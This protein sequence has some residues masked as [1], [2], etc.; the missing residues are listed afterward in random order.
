MRE[1]E[2]AA[3][4]AQKLTKWAGRGEYNTWTDVEVGWFHAWYVGLLLGRRKAMITHE[5]TSGRQSNGERRER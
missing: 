5:Q 1:E 3:A 2:E 4:A